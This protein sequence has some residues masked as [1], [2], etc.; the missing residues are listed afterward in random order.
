MKTLPLILIFALVVGGC[1]QSV[2]ITYTE[3]NGPTITYSR[4]GPQEVG[5]MIIEFP[6]GLQ[7]LMDGSRSQQPPFK[8]T[9][10]YGWVFES[11]EVMP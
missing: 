6:D 10:P 3:L 9:T 7:F 4:K 2:D 5:D 8:V 1:Q 11:G